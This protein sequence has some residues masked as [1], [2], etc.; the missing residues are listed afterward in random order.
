MNAYVDVQKITSTDLNEMAKSNSVF[1]NWTQYKD[2]NTEENRMKME[3]KISRF[4]LETSGNS[5]K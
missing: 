1:E 4:Q 5:Y 3:M 2:D